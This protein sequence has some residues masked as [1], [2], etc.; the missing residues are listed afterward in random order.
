MSRSGHHFEVPLV[1]LLHLS[2]CSCLLRMR[3]WCLNVSGSQNQPGCRD[4]K[5]S[6]FLFLSEH[7]DAPLKAIDFGMA[8]YCLPGQKLEDK[9]GALLTFMPGPDAATPHQ[10]DLH[11][12]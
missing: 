4:V 6:N 7:A 9:A 5:P 1:L 12:V 10:A 3:A 8:T 11:R 2:L